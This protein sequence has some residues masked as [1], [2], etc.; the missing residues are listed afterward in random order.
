MRALSILLAAVP[1]TLAFA[2][3]S[4]SSIDPRLG[5]AAT[6]AQPP[7]PDAAPVGYD[8]GTGLPDADAG[9]ANV[10]NVL[11]KL[12]SSITSSVGASE[13]A[14]DPAGTRLYILSRTAQKVWGFT[15]GP[16]CTL[17]LDA[18]FGTG[19]V[20]V[21]ATSKIYAVPGALYGTTG[22]FGDRLKRIWPV[23]TEEC[24]LDFGYPFAVSD[25]G[26]SAFLAAGDIQNPNIHRLALATCQQTDTGIP[27]A[28]DNNFIS[29]S[30]GPSGLLYSSDGRTIG[31]FDSN[32]NM[33]LVS[34]PEHPQ[35][36]L[37]TLRTVQGCGADLCVLNT[38]RNL[39]DG[40]EWAYLRRYSVAGA[41]K[42][43]LDLAQAIPAVDWKSKSGNAAITR[44]GIAYVTYQNGADMGV[45]QF[46]IP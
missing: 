26:A 12:D 34:F 43:T 28:G 38:K 32:A 19:G 2:C 3:S 42:A 33:E 22:S 40:L 21:G 17:S 46:V 35:A 4:E 30:L 39:G 36:S 23:A 9:P 13:I 25:D 8:G 44:S 41:K 24:D 10:A 7:S 31:V 6:D 37:V 11:C 14:V 20:L 27:V 18:S 5:D 45:G 16:S 15:I 29:L 1:L